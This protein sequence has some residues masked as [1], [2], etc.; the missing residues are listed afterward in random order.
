MDWQP[1]PGSSLL[2]GHLLFGKDFLFPDFLGVS[3][4]P[5]ALFGNLLFGQNDEGNGENRGGR[6]IGRFR[7]WGEKRWK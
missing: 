6:R 1:Q 4:N 3:G 5:V 7:T 2:F